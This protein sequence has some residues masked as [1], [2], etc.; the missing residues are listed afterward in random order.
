MVLR[1]RNDLFEALEV[2]NLDIAKQVFE[3]LAA[4]KASWPSLVWKG[5]I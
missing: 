4:I 2:V 3:Y 5:V 1:S